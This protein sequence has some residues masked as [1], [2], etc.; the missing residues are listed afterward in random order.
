MNIPCHLR[1]LC[2]A[3][4]SFAALGCASASPITYSFAGTVQGDE[5][6]RGYT[7]FSGLFNYDSSTADAIA[8]P[9]TGAYAHG[10][11]YGMSL[12]LD[13]GPTLALNG[14]LN[15]LTTNNLGGADQLGVLAQMG[16][17]SVSLTLW[18]FTQAVL[19][20]DILPGQALSLAD[21]GWSTLSWQGGDGELQGILTSLT[22]V[23]GCDGAA[24]PP[25]PP[26]PPDSLPPNTVPAAIRISRARAAGRAGRGRP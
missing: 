16:G 25:P 3:V 8:D 6:N 7:S 15:V 2:L 26:P 9:S 23:V 19:P 21:F 14:N 11:G 5:A 20:S 17:E 24:P 1:C 18:D 12:T 4:A 10:A 22:C 13:G